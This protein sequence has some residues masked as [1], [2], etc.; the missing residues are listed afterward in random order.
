MEKNPSVEDLLGTLIA[1]TRNCFKQDDV[2]FDNIEMY[3]GNMGAIIKYLD[4][5]IGQIVSSINIQ[6]RGKFPSDTEVN[7]KEQCKVITLKSG[8]E[9]EGAGK[10][11]LV[12]VNLTSLP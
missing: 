11:E 7:P 5:Q 12:E 9:I 2:P 6:Q 4:V 3:M 10:E 1:E 8:K